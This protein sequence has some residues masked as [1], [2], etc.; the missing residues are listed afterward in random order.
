MSKFC[1]AHPCLFQKMQYVLKRR[2]YFRVSARNV[3]ATIVVGS[4]TTVGGRL[5]T[6][7]HAAA[8]TTTTCTLSSGSSSAN[9][10]VRTGAVPTRLLSTEGSARISS[11][12][13]VSPAGDFFLPIIQ[14]IMIHSKNVTRTVDEV[15][16][17]RIFWMSFFQNP[18]VREECGFKFFFMNS[19]RCRGR[20]KALQ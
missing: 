10:A 14:W 8:G 12:T 11:A 2:N 5:S 1:Y 20:D 9:G 13:D 15:S 4:A 17:W 7:R 18:D 19:W 6:G 3:T 16:D